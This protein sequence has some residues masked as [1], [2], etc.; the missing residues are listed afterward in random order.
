MH[1]CNLWT[2]C[3]IKIACMQEKEKLDLIKL[4][5]HIKNLRKTKKLTL[6]SLCYK[7]GLEPSTLCRIE[8]G[9]VEVKYLTLLK[10]AAA[11]NLHVYE[12]LKF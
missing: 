11:F 3:S 7:N 1:A 6:A 9:Q 4:G 8:K 10:I 5:Q 2:D 12:L